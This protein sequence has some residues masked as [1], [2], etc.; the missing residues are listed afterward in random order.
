MPP[1]IPIC[2]LPFFA[3]PPGES[4]EYLTT[5]LWQAIGA[6]N[7]ALWRTDKTGLEL[8]GGNFNAT[9][10]DYGRLGIVLANNGIRPDDPQ[11]AEI[12]PKDY[13]M[14]ATDWHR[15]PKLSSRARLRPTMATVISSGCFQVSNGASHCWR[16]R[17]DD[18]Y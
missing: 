7:S 2:Y 15:V 5:R 6:E 1:P 17:T 12:I 9:L 18:L 13:L 8:A 4:S 11:Q 3:V 14:A 16:I 10:R